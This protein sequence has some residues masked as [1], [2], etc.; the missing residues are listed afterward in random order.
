MTLDSGRG[1]GMNVIKESVV[2]KCGGE[3][4]VNSEPGAFTEFS[5]VIPLSPPAVA[6]LFP[7]PIRSQLAA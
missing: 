3:I 1:V 6:A 2:D 5:F 7:P 4:D